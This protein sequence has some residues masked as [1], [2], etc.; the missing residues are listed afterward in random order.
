MYRYTDPLFSTSALFSPLNSSSGR[1]DESS[2]SD[3]ELSLS[4]SA[5]R[6][7]DI[8]RFIQLL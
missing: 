3:D 5:R 7:C 1:Y 8:F 4:E 6:L 2:Y